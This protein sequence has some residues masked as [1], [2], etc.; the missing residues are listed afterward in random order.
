MTRSKLAKKDILIATYI[1][2]IFLF[3]ELSLKF[4]YLQ[5]VMISLDPQPL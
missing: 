1:G 3:F 5:Q 4:R 2:L